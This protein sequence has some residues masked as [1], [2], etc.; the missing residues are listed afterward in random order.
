ML[1]RVVILEG[2][3]SLHV[4]VKRLWVK[5]RSGSLV[6]RLREHSGASCLLVEFSLTCFLVERMR[7]R[8][9]CSSYSRLLLISSI[10]SS[11][12]FDRLMNCPRSLWVQ[13]KMHCRSSYFFSIKFGMSFAMC[14]FL[15]SCKAVQCSMKCSVS[16]LHGSHVLST[17]YWLNRC[18]FACRV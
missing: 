13:S 15:A 16:M 5:K 3:V 12:L 7:E 2:F 11:V 14:L 18:L 1:G 8:Q 17:S 9:L 10:F 6:V 4:T